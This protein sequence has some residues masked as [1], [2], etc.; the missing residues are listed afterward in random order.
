MSNWDVS[1]VVNTD[2]MFSNATSL[3]TINVN[4][5][6]VINI[7]SMRGMFGG[8]GSY[9][10][11]NNIIGIENWDVSNVSDMWGLFNYCE[12]L[13]TIDLSNW[14]VGNVL[15]MSN[16][17][18][19][20]PLDTTSYDALLIGW[21]QLPSLQPNVSFGANLAK[22]SSGAAATARGILTSAPNNWTITDGG[23]L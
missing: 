6:N 2:N 16:M 19:D 11:I 21:S 5:W 8:N 23:Q 13:T 7:N 3:T 1:N 20:V 18:K 22:Y 12:F 10:D 14:N 15:D 9:M 17:F 4:N